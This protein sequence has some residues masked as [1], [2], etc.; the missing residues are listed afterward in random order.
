MKIGKVE[1]VGSGKDIGERVFPG[2]EGTD[3]ETG[4]MN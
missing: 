3:R 1:L 2:V 4:T